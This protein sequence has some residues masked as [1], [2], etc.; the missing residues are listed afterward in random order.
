[1]A[2]CDMQLFYIETYLWQKW[3]IFGIH[4]TFNS[5]DLIVNSHF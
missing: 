4:L 1:M 5:Q 2:V 3:L